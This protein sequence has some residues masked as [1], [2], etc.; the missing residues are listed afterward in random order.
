MLPTDVGC[1]LASSVNKITHFHVFIRKKKKKSCICLVDLQKK[2]K[3]KVMD[4][5]CIRIYNPLYCCM[6]AN[7]L[8]FVLIISLQ[9]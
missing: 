4:G 5:I 8:E 3:K 1:S 2:K 6:T 9:Q 7:V